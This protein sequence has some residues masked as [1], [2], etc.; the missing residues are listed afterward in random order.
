M[1]DLL[2]RRPFSSHSVR[3]CLAAALAFFYIDAFLLGAPWHVMVFL[4]LVG[5]ASFCGLW[6]AVEHGSLS[7]LSWRD[8]LC[9]LLSTF[10]VLILLHSGLHSVVLAASL[11]GSLG[12]WLELRLSHH[13]FQGMAPACYCGAFVGMT[14]ESVLIDPVLIVL[15]GGLAGGFWS[16]LRQSWIGIGGKMGTMAFL[17]VV[18][19]IGLSIAAGHVGPGVKLASLPIEAVLSILVASVLSPLITQWLSFRCQFGVVL[20]S[21]LPSALVALILLL[22]SHSFVPYSGRLAAAWMGAS[23]VG[24]TNLSIRELPVWTLVLMGLGFGILTLSF[25]PSLL[26]IGGDLGATA[27]ISVLSILGVRL[28]HRGLRP[29]P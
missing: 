25:E 13:H 3:C 28:I 29:V 1:P 11:I 22:F 21:A 6:L 18:L 4:S 14:S 5:L 16:L 27:A 10:F 8:V 26:G 24:M 7:P 23:F 15:A 9:G 12:G 20:G 19:T 17:A 2:G